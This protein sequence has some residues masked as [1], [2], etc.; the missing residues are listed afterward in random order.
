VEPLH[1]FFHVATLG[2]W[3]D[4]YDEIITSLESSGI[5]NNATLHISVVGEHFNKDVSKYQYIHQT[6]DIKTFEYPTLHS[7]WQH[8][9]RHTGAVLYLHTKGATRPGVA[10]DC[11]R[12]MMLHFNVKKWQHALHHLY[13]HHATGCNIQT[14]QNKTFFS[15]N[16][17]WATCDYI[18]TLPDPNIYKVSRLQ[19]ELW[20]GMN[21][22]SKFHN[23]H[24]SLINHYTT[25]YPIENYVH[26]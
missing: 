11:W 16:F 10:V 12:Q 5:L 7:V 13:N 21:P 15:G 6:N 1:I 26:L 24:S 4:V 20:I 22:N 9:H 2:R 8:A 25:A 23:L 14:M 18:K 17:W 3:S 19:A